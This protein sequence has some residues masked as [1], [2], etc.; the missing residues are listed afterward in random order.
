VAVAVVAVVAAGCG[1]A[2]GAAGRRPGT[3]PAAATGV[4]TGTADACSGI[5][6]E[7]TAHLEVYRDDVLVARQQV[8]NGST[9]RFVLPP[10]RY[11]VT[12]TGN[13]QNIG[14]G[15]TVSGGH[16]SELDIADSCF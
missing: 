11:I 10:G 15:V 16:T 12:N 2:H 8:P 1:G 14:D 5:M 4:V 9:Y 6:A 3:T 7:A 13:P